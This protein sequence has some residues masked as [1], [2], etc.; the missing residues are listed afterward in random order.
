[1]R[2][3]LQETLRRDADLRQRCANTLRTALAN[4]VVKFESVGGEQDD[5]EITLSGPW[6]VMTF[7]VESK[8]RVTTEA[9]RPLIAQFK[10]QNLVGKPLFMTEFI[11]PE[12]A[13]I[14]R[15]ANINFVDAAGNIHLNS[16]PLFVW[17]RGFK[18]E[19]PDHRPNRLFQV[20]GLKLL[21]VLLWEPDA[22]NV[23]YR[24][25]AH[26]AG[27]SAGSIVPVFDDLAKGGFLVVTKKHRR[28]TRQQELL[29]QWV[30]GYAGQLFPRLI[31]KTC[32]LADGQSLDS[33]AET[34][35]FQRFGDNVLLGGELVAGLATGYL[36]P[37][38]AAIHLPPDAL[39][40][41]MKYLKL[42]PDTQRQRGPHPAIRREQ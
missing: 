21:S 4:A 15:E 39:A 20:A 8:G 31:L 1:M 18:R 19:T 41:W 36:R 3:T 26:R 33:L 29:E 10:R 32:R 11:H 14:L 12:A 27:V 25:L 16:P 37:T 23:P 17:Q 30:L 35:R 40:T 6:G 24:D 9:I 34:L 5:G 2:P 38:R 13:L 7:T 28:L 42:I 22:V